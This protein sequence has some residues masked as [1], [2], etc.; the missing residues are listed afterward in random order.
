VDAAIEFSK[1]PLPSGVMLK[2]LGS[3]TTTIGNNVLFVRANLAVAFA[4][5]STM[6]VEHFGQVKM[7]Q[8]TQKHGEKTQEPKSLTGTCK[9]VSASFIEPAPVS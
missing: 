3:S 4:L 9:S 2:L 1:R 5:Y 6:T 7:R 8:E